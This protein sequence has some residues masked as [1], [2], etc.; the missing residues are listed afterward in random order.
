MEPEGNT[1]PSVKGK[2]KSVSL[3]IQAKVNVQRREGLSA[4]SRKALDHSSHEEFKSNQFKSQPSSQRNKPQ[5]QPLTANASGVLRHNNQ[6]QN[7]PPSKGKSAPKQ[8][9]SNQQERKAHSVEGHSGKNKAVNKSSGNFRVGYRKEGV[10]TADLD[11]EGSASN[12]KDFPQKKRLIERGFH[13]NKVGFDNSLP[14]RHEKHVQPNVIIDEHTRWK[15]D[16]KRDGMD[17]VSFTFT[18]PLIKP[19]HGSGTSAQ[20][21]EIP[22]KRNAYSFDTSIERKSSTSKDKRL[23]F[24]SNGISGDALSLLLE[25]KLRELT[26][27]V[28]LSDCSF[29]NS[30]CSAASSGLTQE[31]G[32]GSNAIST[33]G[34]Q[35]EA[36]LRRHSSKD[37]SDSIV[38]FG[39]SSTNGQVFGMTHKMQGVEEV[40]CSS[41]SDARKEHPEQQN[42]S[43]LSVLEASFSSES[44][45]SSES[46]VGTNESKVRAAANVSS[47]RTN[48]QPEMELLDSASSEN[49][50]RGYTSNSTNPSKDDL[51]YIRELL[52]NIGD[53][54]LTNATAP[55][56]SLQFDKLEKKRNWSSHRD[57]KDSRLRRKVVFDCVNECLDFRCNRYFRAGYRTWT[58]GVS[59]SRKD[60]AE[61][62]HQEILGWKS[63][64]DWMVDD[65]VD[66]D[67]SNQLGKWADFQIEAFETGVEVE[68]EIVDSLVD[69][70][71]ADFL[72]SRSY[73]YV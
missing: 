10:E 33:A 23:S 4:T 38:G 69:E 48:K 62:L 57:D 59:L 37:K 17:V 65:L 30:A 32:T 51:E 63:M 36:F 14:V 31:S 28:E 49:I 46:S 24:G 53:S 1:L 11:M 44:C 22:D 21:V 18:S 25:Q 72:A 40:E 16:E 70:V 27:G 52:Q 66:K 39:V 47:S 71:I 55:L 20:V 34:A 15:E 12:N 43:P 26:A 35:H 68:K 50:D 41:S 67:M 29:V 19:M 5:K 60:L 2:E 9:M 54:Y 8:S 42:P 3:A 58:K 56:D 6:K 45:N 61:E 13:S 64:G 7:C 73:R